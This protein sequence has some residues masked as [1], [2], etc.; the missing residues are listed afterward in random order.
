MEEEAM[1]R[2][3]RRNSTNKP[4]AIYQWRVR[5]HWAGMHPGLTQGNA[6][7]RASRKSE[8]FYFLFF[9][10]KYPFSEKFYFYQKFQAIF[11]RKTFVPRYSCLLTSTS[12]AKNYYDGW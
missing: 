3:R 10:R 12:A 1:E 7:S 9:W 2:L 5:E 8:D 4:P 6:A 11:V